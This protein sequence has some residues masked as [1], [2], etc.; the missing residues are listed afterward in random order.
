M[1]RVCR[2]VLVCEGWEDSAFLTGFLEGA[3]VKDGIYP[4]N[5]P[6]G[7]GAGFNH[8][9]DVFAKEVVALR[10]FRE[11]R[12]VLAMMDEDGQ[13]V[14]DRRSWVA[15]H[16]E[17]LSLSVMDCT[18]GRCL[19]LTKR[20]IE[21][22]VY[23]LT[24]ARLNENWEVSESDNYKT[25]RP[26]AANRSLEKGDW[27]SAGKQL[28]SIDHTKPPTGMPPELLASLGQLRNFV[29]AVRR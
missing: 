10:G 7:K 29:Q 8:V 21:T 22:W 23:W 14:E 18:Q 27:R 15:S 13:G 5:N 19:V 6:K 1:A 28:H 12:G 9:R 2:I 25:R 4:R 11:G 24:G 3:G 17:S 16:L 26:A 20:N